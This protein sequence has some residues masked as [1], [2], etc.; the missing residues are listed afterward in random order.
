M[1]RPRHTP[2][3]GSG[4]GGYRRPKTRARKNIPYPRHGR[5]RSP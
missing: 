3:P 4:G 2:E 5:H 1:G